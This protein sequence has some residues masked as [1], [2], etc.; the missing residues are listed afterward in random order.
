MTKNKGFMCLPSGNHD[1]SR[2]AGALDE[3]E[4]KL[5][6]AFIMS[7]PGV[8]FVYY[9]DEIGMRYIK[10][11]KSVEGG[12]T[13]TG[14]RTPMQWDNGEVNC[15]FSEASPENLY[16]AIDDSA[17]R[18]TVAEQIS[19]PNSILNEVKRLIKL[20]RQTPAL[21]ECSEFE[22]MSTEQAY[23]LIY[24]R[25]QG[26]NKILV[27]INPNDTEYSYNYEKNI[28]DIIYSVNHIVT[29][30]GTTVKI[31]PCSANFIAL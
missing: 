7:M 14:S 11:V 8:P 15:G 28:S 23:P 26:D 16:I 18:P 2:L 19:N 12:Y 20:R 27:L 10:G 6:F 22:L 29:I 13:R 1:M 30:D 31:P 3:D 4:I 21:Q 25:K 9:G 24:L 5:A 17:D